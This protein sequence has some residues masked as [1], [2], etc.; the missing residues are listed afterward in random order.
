M[1]SGGKR[2]RRE[3]V[4]LCQIPVR[5]SRNGTGRREEGGEVTGAAVRAHY[6]MIAGIIRR[7]LIPAP[8]SRASERHS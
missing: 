8:G 5:L 7:C 2:G 1:P 4:T 6:L 3:E